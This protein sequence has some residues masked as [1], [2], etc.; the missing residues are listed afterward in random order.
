LNVLTKL[1]AATAVDKQRLVVTARTT[2][3]DSE[4]DLAVLAAEWLECFAGGV[5]EVAANAAAFTAAATA[6]LTQMPEAC[7]CQHLFKLS[8]RSTS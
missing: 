3:T 1:A 4:E 8:L 2:T 7:L 6:A 5:S